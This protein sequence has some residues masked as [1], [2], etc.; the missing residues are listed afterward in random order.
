ML[1][2]LVKYK[3]SYMSYIHNEPLWRDQ[4][5]TGQHQLFDLP[6]TLYLVVCEDTHGLWDYFIGFFPWFPLFT[7]TSEYFSTTLASV[8]TTFLPAY[9]GLFP[10][11]KDLRAY[12][13]RI[14]LKFSASVKG[15][16]CGRHCFRAPRIRILVFSSHQGGQGRWHTKIIPWRKGHWVIHNMDWGLYLM[17]AIPSLCTV[18]VRVIWPKHLPPQQ[19]T[20]ARCEKPTESQQLIH[21]QMKYP[22]FGFRLI[23]FWHHNS[24]LFQGQRVHQQDQINWTGFGFSSVLT[25]SA[26]VGP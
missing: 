8:I 14:F 1:V 20:V 21:V 26:A 13:R 23:G 24:E 5:K 10:L 17:K 2:Q 12:M 22:S 11:L 3:M 4:E 15:T 16:S 7:G 18:D 6:S 19:I 25:S 9:Q